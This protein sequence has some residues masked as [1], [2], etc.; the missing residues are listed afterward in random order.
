MFEEKVL[1][2]LKEKSPNTSDET[3]QLYL[4]HV[5]KIYSDVFN[6]SY[7][8]KNSQLKI[9][10]KKIEDYFDE[11]NF[12]P[13]TRANYYSSLFNVFSAMKYNK[14]ITGQMEKMR[15]KYKEQYKAIDDGLKSQKQEDN[16]VSATLLNN[17]IDDYTKQIDEGN[18]DKNLLQIW[19]ILKLIREYSFR[20]EIATLE[21]VTKKE[22]DTS[23]KK[24]E[25]DRNMIV[26]DKKGWFIS[27]NKY[28][29]QKLYGENKIP[30]EGQMLTDLKFYHEI[31]GKGMLFKSSFQQGSKRPTVMTPNA[32]SKYLIKWSKNN[33]P[34]LVLEDGTTKPRSL[35]TTMLVK[36]FQSAKQ[37]EG[38]KE[39]KK[40]SKNRG[41]K[42]STMMDTYVST[43][44]PAV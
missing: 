27:K 2:A 33:I 7:N 29:T 32:L 13:T 28:K 30:V 31:N 16:F 1:S 19:M 6:I 40:D 17:F 21:F 4:N 22:Y 24:E 35:S 18:T 42:P 8:Q 44:E 15:D 5:K 20:N 14:A 26:M 25:K 11:K 38:K 3:Q 39:L 34:P 23:V 36:A 41:N 43:A 9:P 10:W 12:A 37:G